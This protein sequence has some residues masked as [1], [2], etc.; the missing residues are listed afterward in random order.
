MS[1]NLHEGGSV[2]PGTSIA[3]NAIDFLS[4]AYRPKEEV[5]AIRISCCYAAAAKLRMLVT[6][7]GGAAQEVRFNADVALVAQ[8]GYTFTWEVRSDR[9]YNFRHDQAG[10]VVVREFVFSEVTGGAL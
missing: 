1:R 8:A 2:T 5:S 9:T 7:D 3:S 4:S 10:A 6:P